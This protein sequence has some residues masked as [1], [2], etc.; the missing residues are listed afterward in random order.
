MARAQRLARAL[1]WSLAALL[2]IVALG[3]F[4]ATRLPVVAWLIERGS[5]GAVTLV[6]PEGSL[7][8][9]LQVARIVVR[10]AGMDVTLESVALEWQPAALLSNVLHIDRLSAGRVLLQQKPTPKKP[11]EPPKDFALPI[12]LELPDVAVQSLVLQN[13]GKDVLAARDIRLALF[14]G[15]PWLELRDARA[16]IVQGKTE[17]ELEVRLRLQSVAPFALDGNASALLKFERRVLDST[18]RA[19]G[20]LN[21]LLLAATV[22]DAQI[23][24]EPI[25]SADLKL[26]P[27]VPLP[28]AGAKIVAER[29]DP[30]RLQGDWPQAELDLQIDAAQTS[31]KEF[32]GS[33]SV[34]NRRAGPL[35]RGAIPVVAVEG[36]GGGDPTQRL[37]FSP[38]V[39]DLGRGGRFEG[40]ASWQGEQ[41]SVQASTG[42]LDLRAI[43]GSLDATAL[44]GRVEVR[45]SPDAQTATL[46]FREAGK[47][48]VADLKREA[49]KIAFRASATGKRIGDVDVRGTLAEDDKRGLAVYGRVAHLDLSGLGAFPVSNLNASFSAEGQLAQKRSLRFQLDLAP[50]RLRGYPLA[51][52]AHGRWVERRIEDLDVALSAGANSIHALGVLAAEGSRFAWKVDAPDLAQVGPQFAGRLRG[53]GTVSGKLEAISVVADLSADRLRLPGK[54]QVET[55]RLSGEAQLA[56]DAPFRLDAQGTKLRVG[57]SLQIDTLSAQGRGSST[58]HTLA[59]AAK[60]SDFDV[61]ARLAGSYSAADTSWRGKV[62]QLEN[63]GTQE[64]RLEAPAALLLSP[65]HVQVDGAVLA[66]GGGHIRLARFSWAEGALA[67]RGAVEHL[68]TAPLIDLARLNVI[69]STLVMSGEWD[70]RL[71]NQRL[72]GRVRLGRDS[73]DVEVSMESALPLGLK[74]V[75]VLLEVQDNHARMDARVI[76]ELPGTVVAS[77]ATQLAPAPNGAIG[78]PLSSPLKG[79]LSANIPSLRWLAALVSENLAFD[80]KLDARLSASG[81]LRQPLLTGSIAGRDL[82]VEVV[83]QGVSLRD[84]HFQAELADRDVVLRELRFAGGSGELLASGRASYSTDAPLAGIEWEARKLEIVKRPDRHIVVSGRGKLDVAEKQVEVTGKL[85]MDEGLIQLP[86]TPSM[87][88]SDD[89]VV[90][91]RPPPRSSQGTTLPLKLDLVADLGNHFALRGRGLETELRGSLHI[92]SAGDGRVLATGTVSTEQGTYRAY[93]QKLEIDHGVVGFSGAIDNPSLD[94]LALRKGGDVEAGVAIQGTAQ[95]P[96]VK[97][98]STPNV[99][100]TEKLSWLVLGKGTT[101][102]SSADMALL[103]AAA[104]SLLE[105]SAAS[106][107]QQQLAGAFGLDEISIR[108]GDSKTGTTTGNSTLSGA[109]VSLGKRISNKVYVGYEQGLSGTSSL[110]KISYILSQRWT[111]R[112]SAGSENAVDVFY[113]FRFD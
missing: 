7:R 86:N 10:T 79:S 57:E 52:K 51:G 54:V 80:G 58:R 56:R 93:G 112:L 91:G 4:V 9:P 84:G 12:E 95:R 66:Y 35:D 90:R 64:V 101:E 6:E 36:K 61:T 46:D 104:S 39:I 108:A 37:D 81:T 82:N 2:L 42:R 18:L 34:R 63:R 83:E 53:A 72:D 5:G 62:E 106:S 23:R 32:H 20:T 48:L 1:L 85:T 29:I 11:P 33:V 59:L 31:E 28:I 96:A 17:A 16:N 47:E 44:A 77:V 75:S 76:G 111:A 87:V 22:T 40:E 69:G 92:T 19:G 25:A 41:V 60:G 38:L 3:L 24:P 73:G 94:I 21:E 98:V 113:R 103:Q 55:L 110:V 102:G 13:E 27:F 100:D 49:G 88:V 97:L 43:H 30:S 15:R 67:T 68:E 74:E 65:G 105:K 99:P 8:G 70:L 71:A 26:R 89:V 14:G 109:V 45:A 78:L 50:S 107:M